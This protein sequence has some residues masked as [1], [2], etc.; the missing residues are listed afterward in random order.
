MLQ[1]LLSEV[2]NCALIALPVV[3]EQR[4]AAVPS[5]TCSGLW[6]SSTEGLKASPEASLLQG[7]EWKCS[8]ELF[9]PCWSCWS[10]VRRVDEGPATAHAG[11][12][13]K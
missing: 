12:A 6:G 9:Q 5:G 13:H 1:L 7:Q 10:R 8:P 11:V 2:V 3:A 4:I